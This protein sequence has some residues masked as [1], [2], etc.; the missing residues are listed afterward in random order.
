MKLKKITIP[1]TLDMVSEPYIPLRFRRE[2]VVHIVK[3][4]YANMFHDFKTPL[5][6]A[7]SGPPGMGKTYQANCVLDT[8]EIKKFAISGAEFENE[9]AG[10]PVKNL[11]KS[12]K[13]VSD[14]I[15]YKKIKYG[16]ILIDD[17]DAAIGKW[18]G[19]VQYTMNRQLLIKTLIDFADN[20]YEL[21][22]VDE[23]DNPVS[24]S[25]SRVPIIITLN[26]ETKMY[27]PLMRNGRTT[28]FPWIPNDNEISSILEG[29]FN[30]IFINKSAYYLYTQ[31][32]EYANDELHMNVNELPISLFSDIK[33]SLLDDYIWEKYSDSKSFE[34][35][36]AAF[37]ER[38]SSEVA[39]EFSEVFKIGQR[40]LHQNK[41]YLNSK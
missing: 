21:I 25:T 34:S 10:V 38:I 20:P 19:L 7:I 22:T 12:Y 30:N 14:D 3:N 32:L 26:D 6:L 9:N 39:Y 8:L 4:F 16:A 36:V 17:I 41:N 24:Y 40:L 29:I 37:I 18:D 35:A 27:E 2:I 5:I 1:K 13:R 33:S 11:Q 31:L 23:D 15:Y 28:V